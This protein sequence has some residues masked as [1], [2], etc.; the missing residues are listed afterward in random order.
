[1]RRFPTVT[2]LA[3]VVGE[4]IGVSGWHTITQADIDKFAD[5]TGD[6]QWI[7][8]DPHR[9]KDGP[10]GTTIAHGYLTLSLIAGLEE[11]IY[12]VEDLEMGINYGSERVRFLEPVPSGTRVRMRAELLSAESA[13][14]GLRTVIKATVEIEGS[15]KP[16]CV[17]E[18]V[19]ILVPREDGTARA[20]AGGVH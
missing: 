15:A 19:S 5:A 13:P 17:A 10:F 14:T 4:E 20:R 8:V 11:Q 18:V 16:A 1:M 6:H 7:H 3:Q 12:V 2:A 9:A